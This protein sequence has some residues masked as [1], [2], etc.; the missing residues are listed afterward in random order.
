MHVVGMLQEEREDGGQQPWTPSRVLVAHMREGG[1]ERGDAGRMLVD[2]D[3][4]DGE[5][6]EVPDNPEMKPHVFPA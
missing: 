5:E 3:G 6:G 4:W 2:E 1:Q